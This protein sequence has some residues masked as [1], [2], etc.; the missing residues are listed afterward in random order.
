[1]QQVSEAAR[2]E[3]ASALAMLEEAYA[4]RQSAK[5]E[6]GRR[7][8]PTDLASEREDQVAAAVIEGVR[9]ILAVPGIKDYGNFIRELKNLAADYGRE[10]KSWGFVMVSGAQNAA[11]VD[12]LC[13]NSSRTGIAVRTWAKSIEYLH[14]DTGEVRLTRAELAERIGTDT[15][16]ISRVMGELESINAIRRE[17]SGGGVT[18]FVNPGI[19]TC[20]GAMR[21]RAE[22]ERAGDLRL[23]VVEG[24]RA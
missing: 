20:L 15:R 10:R 1:M 6:A 21:R 12:W 5:G 22:Q 3:L 7:R 2:S 18:Y 9:S 23:E 24:G 4:A 17:R 16:T 11:V 8:L 13:A 19:A 14:P